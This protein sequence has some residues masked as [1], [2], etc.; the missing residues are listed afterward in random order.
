MHITKYSL[1]I[2]IILSNLYFIWTT[3]LLTSNK[4]KIN[5]NIIPIKRSGFQMDT[6]TIGIIIFISFTILVA[7]IVLYIYYY[8][9]ADRETLDLS[10]KNEEKDEAVKKDQISNEVNEKIEK[11]DEIDELEIKVDGIVE[12][13]IGKVKENLEKE[14]KNKD[15]VSQS[16]N[17]I[18]IK[19]DNPINQNKEKNNNND[20][21]DKIIEDQIVR[22]RNSMKPIDSNFTDNDL[23]DIF[24]KNIKQMNRFSLKKNDTSVSAKRFVQLQIQKNFGIYESDNRSSPDSSFYEEKKKIKID[25]I[26]KEENKKI[27][28]ENKIEV[29]DNNNDLTYTSLNKINFISKKSIENKD[30]ISSIQNQKK[31]EV[32]CI[33]GE[34]GG[35]DDDTQILNSVNRGNNQPDNTLAYNLGK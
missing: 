29:C 32:S 3:I 21:L 27:D 2:L 12:K 28:E 14:E 15:S 1:F 17:N 34:V 33:L 9:K 13:V 26:K 5:L 19:E 31:N 7:A 30:L 20:W 11:F 24:K 16:N 22:K 18:M 10:K 6:T 4:M 25:E 23:K 35:N 8:K